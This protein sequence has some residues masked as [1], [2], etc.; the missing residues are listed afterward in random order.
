MKQQDGK[1]SLRMKGKDVQRLQAALG[2]IGF[3]IADREGYFGKTTRQAVLTFQEQQELE[4]TGVV[5]EETAEL[6]NREVER[7]QPTSSKPFAVKG[8]VVQ[9]EGAAS[10]RPKTSA[11]AATTWRAEADIDI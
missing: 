1:L 5:D 7:Q 6:I 10:S 8:R 3:S 2:Q 11:R 9:A 4:P